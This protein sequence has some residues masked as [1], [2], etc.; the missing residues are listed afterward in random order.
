MVAG[1]RLLG[2]KNL[3]LRRYA[4]LGVLTF[5]CLEPQP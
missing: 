1:L 3:D 2:Q 4:R 5:C